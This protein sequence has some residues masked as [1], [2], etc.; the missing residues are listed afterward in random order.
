MKMN[1][2]H[3]SQHNHDQGKAEQGHK[4]SRHDADASK[5]FQKR[6]DPGSC[7]RQGNSDGREDGGKLPGAAAEFRVPVRGEAESCQQL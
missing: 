5:E 2:E 7:M 4:S 1:A 3:G 6:S